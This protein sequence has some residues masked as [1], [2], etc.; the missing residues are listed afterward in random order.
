MSERD[1]IIDRLKPQHQRFCEEYV[2]QNFN[3]TRAYKSVYQVVKKD[4]T[5]KASASKLLTKSNVRAYIDFLKRE[6]DAK[7]LEK[8]GVTM[9]RIVKERAAIAF[10]T[11]E[12][13]QEDW[14]KN[15]DWSQVNSDTK[16]AIS[17]VKLYKNERHDTEGNIVSTKTTIITKMHDKIRALDN[18]EE[19]LTGAKENE[20]T[21]QSSAPVINVNFPDMS[22]KDED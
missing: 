22:G 13:I 18:L 4:S 1:E 16:K 2:A 20:D 11:I 15:K 3:G 12:D 6:N 10:T 19:M 21:P 7:A 17:E 9:E 8:V 5:A 14:G